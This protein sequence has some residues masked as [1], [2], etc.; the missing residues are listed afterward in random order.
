MGSIAV[1]FHSS[2]SGWTSRNYWMRNALL[3]SVQ[4]PMYPTRAFW[5]KKTYESQIWSLCIAKRCNIV[6]SCH[7]RVVVTLWR[8]TPV[9]SMTT[10]LIHCCIYITFLYSISLSI[11]RWHAL[12]CGSINLLIIKLPLFLNTC[13]IIKPLPHLIQKI[14]T[15]SAKWIIQWPFMLQMFVQDLICLLTVKSRRF[16]VKVHHLGSGILK[17]ASSYFNVQRQSAPTK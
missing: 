9:V 8:Q 11:Q 13:Y 12:L 16:V 1:K 15:I 14:A 17:I 5:K 2:S 6:M 3:V 10:C 7:D 4:T